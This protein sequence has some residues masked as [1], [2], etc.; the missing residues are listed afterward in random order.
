MDSMAEEAARRAARDYQ[1]AFDR[2]AQ[3][4]ADHVLCLNNDP[5]S[6]LSTRAA[7]V[8]I[9]NIV[10]RGEVGS[11]VHGIS[12]G[13]S[14]DDRDEMAVF[15]GP[16]HDVLGLSPVEHFVY[17]TAEVRA[18]KKGVPSQP[19]DLDFTAYSLTK[20]ARLACGGNPSVM[21]L[22][23]TPDHTFIDLT[24][25]ARA[26]R[27]ALRGMID[28]PQACRRFLGYAT[29]QVKKMT[30]ERNQRTKRPEIVAEHGYDSKFAAHAYR[31]A[32]QG[33]AFAETGVMPIPLHEPYRSTCLAMRRG[34]IDARSALG[35]ISGLIVELEDIVNDLPRLP[36]DEDA[37]FRLDH[38]LA[39][40][41]LLW[42][43]RR[44]M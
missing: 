22:L 17:R 1:A 44:G 43:E 10:M 32:A 18:R 26:M 15:I 6:P 5:N 34:E 13:E 31:L 29:A 40:T 39:R 20:F 37:A 9:P 27:A 11:T 36:D 42:W 35:M 19:G 41:A 8:A 23:F 7:H 28:H 12:L 38:Y 30:G 16:P 25:D 24:Q 2:L 14:H 3:H 33:I 4:D 21:A